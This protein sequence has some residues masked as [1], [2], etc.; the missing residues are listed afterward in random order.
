MNGRQRVVFGSLLLFGL[1][2]C[3]DDSTPDLVAPPRDL[4]PA[5]AAGAAFDAN[6]CG[7]IEGRVVWDSA[8]P[9]VEP[10]RTFHAVDNPGPGGKFLTFEENPF[11]PLVDPEGRGLQDAVVYLRDVDA[12]RAR[13]WRHDPVLVEIVGRRIQVVQGGTTGRVGLVLR[14]ASIEVVNRDHEYHSLRARGAAFFC[15]PLAEP[16]RPSRR[17]L[18]QAGVVRL[19]SGA[20]YAWMH[21][22]LLVADHPYY[23]RTDARGGFRLE[24]VPAG[25]YEAVCWMPSWVI[26]RVEREP[27]SGFATRLVFASPI[28]RSATVT[29]AARQTST[30]NFKF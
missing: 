21:A 18:D 1:I 4:A 9:D 3:A 11:R 10:L 28:E 22:N 15:L 16:D 29:V 20:G 8:I 26:D 14:G 5:A 12:R 25:S 6:T 30:L 17:R 23:A 7:T 19:F 24:D 2:G 27:E 13:P